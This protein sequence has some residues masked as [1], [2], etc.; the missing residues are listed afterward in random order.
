MNVRTAR[1][2][3]TLV[4]AACSGAPPALQDS[5]T[6]AGAPPNDAGGQV[7][8]DAGM[9]AGAD[10]ATL[11][12][13][14]IDP[15][16]SVPLAPH[17]SGVNSEPTLSAMQYGNSELAANTPALKVGWF[18]FPGGTSS[19]AFDWQTG[20]Y[21]ASWV[22]VFDGGYAPPGVVQAGQELTNGKGGVRVADH[23]AFVTANGASTIIDVNTI[24]D[25]PED[26]GVFAAWARDAGMTVDAWELCNEPYF[27]PR[28]YAGATDYVAK[29]EPFRTQI[30]KSDSNANVVVFFE[31]LYPG[32]N[33][34]TSS[35]DDD[36]ASVQNPWW[37]GVATHIYPAVN[38]NVPFSNLQQQFNGAL[39]NVASGYITRYLLPKTGPNA[40]LYISEY[41]TA[42][43]DPSW[44]TLYGA[45]FL[46]EFAIRL[47]AIPNVKRI[48]LHSFYL[49]NTNAWGLLRATT[50]HDGQVVNAFRSGTTIDTVPLSFGLFLSVP[51]QAFSTINPVLNGST[52]SLATTVGAGPRVGS[53]GFGGPAEI[54][55]VYAQA[56]AGT[57]GTH[58]VLVINKGAQE[59]R[60]SLTYASVPVTA[61]L[62]VTSVSGFDPTLQNTSANQTAIAANHFNAM[63]PVSLGP[64]SVTR[65]AW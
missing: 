41:G 5:G 60:V 29:V 19:V 39:A 40:S 36:L 63:S 46:S 26:A 4:L 2:L 50:D 1:T 12:P 9:D 37:D 57:D 25:S 31:G 62:A 52:S 24:T 54:P 23:A 44:L 35:W 17:F 11:V 47:S 56:Y 58:Y 27:F 33:L 32:V 18:R 20:L 28:A 51:G 7:G 21:P 3:A 38:Y 10:A 16:Q 13:I 6:D 8:T 55:A 43:S 14:S 30:K 15:T 65:I 34:T 49:G 48:G 59:V 45:V 22:A 42:L 61:N 53:T 64:Y